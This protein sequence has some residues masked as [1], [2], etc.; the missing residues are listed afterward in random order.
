MQRISKDTMFMAYYKKTQ[1]KKVSDIT[2][3]YSTTRSTVE[4]STTYFK[5]DY[6]DNVNKRHQIILGS[7]LG[8]GYL[9]KTKNGVYKYRESHGLG[10]VEYAMWKYLMLDDWTDNTKICPKNKTESGDFQAVELF[11]SAKASEYIEKYYQLSI[12][13]VIE[14][15]DINGLIVYLLDDGWYSNHSKHGNFCV[16][17]TIL[18]ESQLKS[19]QDRFKQYGIRTNLIGKKRQCISIDAQDNIVLFAHL[20]KLF[21]FTDL[22]IINKKF[23]NIK[24][25]LNQ[26]TA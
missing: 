12:E 22:D 4:W 21:G 24:Q 6:K 7:I 1:T 16:M 19:I 10:E 14:N 26:L 8:D 5:S 20:Q 3:I 23:E 2:Q 17:S 11:T 25:T 18:S 13:K 9:Q 15:I